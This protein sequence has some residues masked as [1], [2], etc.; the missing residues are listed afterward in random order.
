M[1][2]ETSKDIK[3]DEESF[4]DSPWFDGLDIDTK[5]SILKES[6]LISL[7]KGEALFE[8]GDLADSLYLL[9]Q[10]SLKLAI[11]DAGGKEKIV[12]IFAKG[13]VIWESVFL[14]GS[15]FPF[16]SIAINELRAYKIPQSSFAKAIASTQTAYRVIALLSKKLHDANERNLILAK[17]NAKSRVAG[18]LLYRAER[19][20]KKVFSLR[21]EEIA[22]S[23]SLREETVSRKISE[24]IEEGYLKKV[25]QS[26]FE[27]IDFASL[28][29]I[30]EI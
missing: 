14:G 16:S 13:E 5:T 28:K 25:G 24:L 21:L 7:N 26:G 9:V 19:S 27:I 10:G 6:K 11:Y 2:E 18:F 17:S 30:S 3:G 12:G 29:E 22:A 15:F 23:V 20:P 1:E 8:V 4:L